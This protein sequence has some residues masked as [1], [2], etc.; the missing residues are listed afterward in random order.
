[1]QVNG[2]ATV[3]VQSMVP[4]RNNSNTAG[5]Q[6]T[7]TPDSSHETLD[8]ALHA[9]TARVTQ[10]IS[11][12]AAASAWL[13][14]ATH[15]AN[16]PGRQ[17]VLAEEA[18]RLGWRFLLSNL[19]SEGSD[20]SSESDGRY[21]HPAW[22]A[23]PLCYWKQA[24][25]AQESWWEEATR[26][27]RG[28]RKVDADRVRFMVRQ[29]LDAIAP[30]NQ[31][32]VNPEVIER[33]VVTK[34]ES[35][36]HG[37]S[38]L[39][40]DLSAELSGTE[41]PWPEGFEIGTDIAATP[42]KIVFRNEL[43]ELIQYTPTTGEVRP[44]PV[45]FVPAWIMK[46]YILDLSPGN[47]LVS[48]LVAQGF[49]VFMISWRNPDA[50]QSDLSLEDYRRSGIMAALDAVTGITGAARVHACGYCLGG[51]ILAI[52]A[53]VLAREGKDQLASITLL[54]AQT[55][56][57][58]AGELMLFVDESQIAFLEDMMWDRGVL[59]GRQ[60]TGTFRALRAQ[61]LIWTRAM[62]RYWL[63]EDEQ[64][65]DITVWNADS[66]RMPYRMHAE[67]L[68]GLF[69]ENR[70][71]AGRFAVEDRVIALKDI[72]VPIFVLGTE[73]DHI[74]PWRSVYKTALFTDCDLSFVLTSGGHNGGVLSSPDKKNH[75][76]RQGHRPAGR[77]YMDPDTWLSL[78][79]EQAGSWWPI[80]GSWLAQISTDPGPPPPLGAADQGYPVLGLAPGT[81]VR[82]K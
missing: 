82:Q 40:K 32:L 18:Q 13:D 76:F 22:S 55:D 46:Y 1:M 16:A 58:E 35:L 56:F 78:H 24:Y 5:A 33:A 77:H 34:G 49:T 6:M 31:P 62:R 20:L 64:P 75:H 11:P 9:A 19:G 65:A 63:G 45:L 51:T 67:Y 7:Q 17:Q 43:F 15:L 25:L 14:W 3:L 79:D 74:A 30:H 41:T 70:L 10:G 48:W 57:S 81:Y 50:S 21:S 8:R 37:W 68:R 42:G 47:S 4:A 26:E 23:P 60:M 80:W 29:S 2:T 66:T 36:R 52:A 27:I 28:M 54:A 53:A 59:D 61:D 69:L 44:E 71:T 12:Y 39:L 38:S 73:R 72:S